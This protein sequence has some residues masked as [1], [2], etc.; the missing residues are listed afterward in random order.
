MTRRRA[1]CGG[2]RVMHNRTQDV[3]VTIPVRV[4]IHE[5]R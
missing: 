4:A 1:D 2:C 3:T 5:L